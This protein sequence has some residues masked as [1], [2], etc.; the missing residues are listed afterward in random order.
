MIG[1]RY[2]P[3]DASTAAVGNGTWIGVPDCTRAQ[4]LAMALGD[5]SVRLN[6][7]M[8]LREPTTGFGSLH[9]GG[10]FLLMGEGS[11]RFISQAIDLEVFRFLSVIDEGNR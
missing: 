8:P 5:A 4:G 6:I 3:A 9:H 2:S 10:A 1:E 7:G 11:A